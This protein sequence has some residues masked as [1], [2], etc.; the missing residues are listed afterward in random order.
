MSAKRSAKTRVSEY[1]EVKEK[2]NAIISRLERN[3]EL[4]KSIKENIK[5][6]ERYNNW[7]Q[8]KGKEL[9]F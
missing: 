6:I 3:K 7:W 4:S 1:R 2:A 9:G 5:D 8:R